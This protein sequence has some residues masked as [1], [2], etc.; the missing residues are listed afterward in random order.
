MVRAARTLQRASG[1][2]RGADI[3]VVKAIPM[4]AGLGGGSSD[5][6]TT[7]MV[8]DRL[9]ATGFGTQRLQALGLALGADVPF[10]LF[11]R[12]DLPDLAPLYARRWSIEQCF[13]NLKGRG[14]NLEKTHLRC[15]LKLRKL[16]A[17]VSLA[18]ALCRSVGQDA[19]EHSPPIARKKH[20]YRAT[21]L[22]RHGLNILRQITRPATASTDALARQVMALLNWL[23][24]QVD[25][26]QIPG[27]MVG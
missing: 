14:F 13:Q 1:T 22:S 21:S 25:C 24:L 20:G 18:D 12:A 19:T 4:G 16:L 9:W 10:F 17:L 8:L 2:T 23:A 27:K 6:A 5:A 26:Y 11:G 7:L 3:E 15:H